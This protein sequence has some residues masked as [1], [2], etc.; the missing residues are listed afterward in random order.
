MMYNKQGMSI[1]PERTK[2]VRKWQRPEDRKAVKS[3]LQTA[4]FCALFMRLGEG[5]IYSEVTWPLRQLTSKKTRFQWTK[6][7]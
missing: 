5:R 4:Q 2:A 6:E 1:D 7:F 3:F